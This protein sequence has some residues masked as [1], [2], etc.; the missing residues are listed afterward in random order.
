MALTVYKMRLVY[1][2]YN[3]LKLGKANVTGE[4][5]RL[6]ILQH[7]VLLRLI[8]TGLCSDMSKKDL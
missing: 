5:S 3:L 1:N 4:A 2:L 7:K 6:N 8:S